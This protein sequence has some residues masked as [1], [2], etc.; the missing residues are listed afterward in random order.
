MHAWPRFGDEPWY[1]IVAATFASLV[2]GGQAGEELGWRGYALPRM[3]RRLGMRGASLLLGVLWAGW[4]LPLFLLSGIDK[5]G[6]SFPVY[7]LQVTAISVAMAW[8]YLH[9]DGSLLLAMLMHSAIN[10][11]KDLVP[12]AVA[13]ATDPFAWSGSPVAWLTVAFLWI[14]AAYFLIRMPRRSEEMP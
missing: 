2:I 11:S 8:L 5:S 6:Q 13:G 3:A 1:V 14:G 12:S 10:Q 7:L 4:H 9:T